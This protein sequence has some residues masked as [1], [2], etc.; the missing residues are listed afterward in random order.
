MMDFP[1][2]T[3]ISKAR[4]VPGERRRSRFRPWAFLFASLGVLA[5]SVSC[6]ILAPE[7]AA[8]PVSRESN[9]LPKLI[10]RTHWARDSDTVLV[11]TNHGLI[12]VG[13]DSGQARYPFQVP[14]ENVSSATISPDGQTVIVGYRDGS[15]AFENLMF[16]T[17]PALKFAAH[18]GCVVDV[19]CTADGCSLASACLDGSLCIWQA[20]GEK[21]W[22]LIGISPRINALAF[23]PD[24]R[25]LATGD[26]AGTL[27]LFDLERGQE[28]LSIETR[29]G[30]LER[31]VFAPDGT[32]LYSA[33]RDVNTGS[34][35]GWHLP[36]GKPVWEPLLQE[37]GIVALD[38]SSDGKWMATGGYQK[39]VIVR[40]AETG[41]VTANIPWIGA[42]RSL[43][44]SSSGQSLLLT[45][46]NGKALHNCSLE[47]DGLAQVIPIWEPSSI[48]ETLAAL[49]QLGL[50]FA[51]N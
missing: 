45:T 1:L 41:E 30:I 28:C 19:A 24:G 20:N 14:N 39:K 33:G 16:E 35:G 4:A 11:V 3:T 42:V 10:F 48:Q 51:A 31:L 47:M 17:G 43:Q 12:F 15:V 50:R 2:R 9:P 21:L 8:P 40:N 44:F 34:I 25:T 26:V 38:I 49:V 7:N 23:S 22:Q 13:L 5:V 46:E 29:Q 36:F 27:R 32:R 18:A 6:W 37:S